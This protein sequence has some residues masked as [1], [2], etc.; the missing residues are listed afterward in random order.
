M[1]KIRRLGC[2]PFGSDTQI[3]LKI[4]L[5]SFGL[6]LGFAAVAADGYP[7]KANPEQ[8]I[9]P[10]GQQKQ[11]SGKVSDSTGAPIPGATIMVTGANIGTISDA[12]G[13]FTLNIPASA[14]SITVSF[15]GM[16]TQEV[17]LGSVTNYNVVLAETNVGLEE[18]VVVGYG[19]QK[20]E[21]VIGAITQVNNAALMKS[22]TQNIT[23]AITGKLSG[24]LTI[25]QTGEPGNDD[26]EVII[27]GISSWN[28]S[29]PLALVDGVE[30]DYKDLDPAE[31]NTVSVLK[32][33]FGYC[34]IRS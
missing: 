34:S 28:G 30:R 2:F 26:S 32:R 21:S 19:T 7:G 10:V 18:V 31:I 14:K 3:L 9:N 22:G 24:V 11:I 15:V 25:Q 27:R 6:L 16:V 8:V 1:K 17:T 4:K 33:C 23:N 5:L 13:K 20:K 12:D 29:A